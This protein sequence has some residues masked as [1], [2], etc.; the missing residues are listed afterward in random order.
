[1]SFLGRWI[2]GGSLWF[3]SRLPRIFSMTG[4]LWWLGFQGEKRAVRKDVESGPDAESR[5]VVEG[6]EDAKSGRDANNG[7]DTNS[8]QDIRCA[9]AVSLSPHLSWNWS[10]SCHVFDII[11]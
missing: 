8:S 5:Q 2:S 10:C 1:M 9:G 11:I 7:Q 6:G 4:W 3:A